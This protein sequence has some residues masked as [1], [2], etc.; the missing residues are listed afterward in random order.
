M[1]FMKLARGLAACA[2]N[3]RPIY[4]QQMPSS[5]VA[6][7]SWWHSTHEHSPLAQVSVAG[8]AFGHLCAGQAWIA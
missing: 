3:S 5:G 1:L 4:W 2:A 7:L 6:R 8:H